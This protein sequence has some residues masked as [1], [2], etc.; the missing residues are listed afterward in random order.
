MQLERL[1][2]FA[3]EPWPEEIDPEDIFHVEE[4]DSDFGPVLSVWFFVEPE[5]AF[6]EA[7]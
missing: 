4:Y 5:P 3:G 1:S 6:D 2:V 7:A